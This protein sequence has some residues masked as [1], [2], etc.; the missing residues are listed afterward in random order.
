MADVRWPRPRPAVTPT[1]LD[2]LERDMKAGRWNTT[3]MA[4]ERSAGL[5]VRRLFGD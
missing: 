2:G 4:M 3:I 5:C 1:D